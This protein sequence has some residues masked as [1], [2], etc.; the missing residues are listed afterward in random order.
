MFSVMLSAMADMPARGKEWIVLIADDD[1]DAADTLAAILR[2]EGYLVHAVYDGEKALEVAANLRPDIVLLDITMPKLTGYELA[3]RFREQAGT[4]MQLLIA[5]TGTRSEFA[6]FRA[7]MA[8]FDHYFTKPVDPAALLQLL[9]NPTTR[10][11]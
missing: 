2:A 8:G 10:K 6:R 4:A 5:V 11:A 9:A 1:R 7:E 3:Q